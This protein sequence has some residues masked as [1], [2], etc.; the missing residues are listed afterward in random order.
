[1]RYESKYAVIVDIRMYVI[2]F[3]DVNLIVPV[4][5]NLLPTN[6]KIRKITAKPY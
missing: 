4:I 5:F 3:T 1:M 2:Y 6:E